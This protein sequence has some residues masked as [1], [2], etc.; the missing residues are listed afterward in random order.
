[1]RLSFSIKRI[2][3]FWRGRRVRSNKDQINTTKLGAEQQLKLNN[4]LR[5]RDEQGILADDALEEYG[6]LVGENSS[7]FIK[8]KQRSALVKGLLKT[9]AEQG[10]LG[11]NELQLLGET[12]G[13]NSVVFKKAKNRTT[14][15]ASLLKTR[16][17]QGRLNQDQLKRLME[18]AREESALFK[19]IFKED[20]GGD[21][22][23]LYH[24]M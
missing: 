17:V 6:R 8:E 22:G 16:G 20:L 24:N 4:L 2:V 18:V 1:M 21:I 3:N 7:F 11:L 14:V 15:I 12:A 13:I 19:R 10:V 9:E 23:Q 5:V